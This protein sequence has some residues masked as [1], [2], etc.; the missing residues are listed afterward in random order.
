MPLLSARKYRNGRSPVAA[1]DDGL[2]QVVDPALAIG[3]L[4]A[5]ELA[6]DLGLG[7]AVHLA[8][9]GDVDVAQERA[10]GRRETG[11]EQQG[12]PER[13]GAE[14]TRQAHG[15]VGAKASSSTTS[16]DSEH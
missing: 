2:V 9:R 5:L 11:P 6:A 12:Q 7:A 13:R 4:Q 1:L 15:V 10:G 3:G 8:G 16:F 14:E